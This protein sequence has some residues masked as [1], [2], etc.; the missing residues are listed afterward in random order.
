MELIIA[1]V[2]FVVIFATQMNQTA[3][4]YN[5][6]WARYEAEMKRFKGFSDNY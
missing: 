6:S 3:W 4:A 1:V 2:C 5:R